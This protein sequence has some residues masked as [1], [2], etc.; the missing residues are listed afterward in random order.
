MTDIRP[1]P[2]QCEYGF[3]EA[4]SK[5][6]VEA[7]LQGEYTVAFLMIEAARTRF[8]LTEDEVEEW[9]RRWGEDM[10]GPEC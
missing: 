1:L 4:A 2:E 8:G 5:A 6:L 3:T 7:R 10:L 9:L